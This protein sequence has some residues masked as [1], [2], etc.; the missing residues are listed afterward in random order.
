MGKNKVVEPSMTIKGENVIGIVNISGH[1]NANISQKVTR[2]T[3]PEMTNLFKELQELVIHRQEDSPVEKEMIKK[4]IKAIEKEASKGAESNPGRLGK[5]LN[6]LSRMAPDILDVIIA[7]LEGP[8][9]GFTAVFKK[10]AERAKS[11]AAQG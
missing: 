1:A 2:Q 10:I 11:A 5:L 3:S 7:S 4:K 9:T 8:V 6:D